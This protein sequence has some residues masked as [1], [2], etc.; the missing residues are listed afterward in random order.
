MSTYQRSSTSRF[1]DKRRSG[2]LMPIFSLPSKYGI[3][4]MGKEAY[5]FID[6]LKRSGQSYWQVLPLGHT[7]YGNSP[8]QCFSSVAGNPYFIDLD[9]LVEM[10]LLTSNNLV[11]LEPAN[12]SKVDY[13]LLED[14]RMDILRVAFSNSFFLNDDIKAFYYQNLDWIFDY[15]LFMALKN[16]FGQKPVWEWDDPSIIRREEDAIQH[17]KELLIGDIEF[18]IFIQY[19]FFKQWKELKAYANENGIRFIGDIPMYPSPDSCDVWCDPQYFKVDKNLKPTW[20][21][22]VPPDDFSEDGQVWGNPV[23]DWDALKEGNYSWWIWRIYHTL[24]TADIIRIDHFRAFQD[25]FQIPAGEDTAKNG[26]WM[27]GPGMDFFDAMK[28][29]FGELPFILEDLGIIT[30]SV[31]NLRAQ[32]GLPGMRVMVF[33]FR[34]NEDNEHMPHNWEAD[35]IAYTSTHDSE[36]VAQ[37]INELSDED[38]AFALNYINYW[39]IPD[40]DNQGNNTISFSAIRSA[41]ASHANIVIVAM[42]DLLSLG[43]EGRINTPSTIG[44][45]NWTWRIAPDSLEGKLASDFRQLTETFKRAPL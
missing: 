27:P 28:D 38:Y 24:D 34:A 8:Y 35:S 31:R 20:I 36:T 41:M 15:A 22:G 2:V 18:Y 10:G 25:Y 3:G 9:K 43:E 23:Y 13:A 30:D 32:T 39:P 33:G 6:F 45:H 19:L 14:T 26:I 1:F 42:P 11:G 17:Y 44:D 4:T 12:P 40:L 29:K 5:K 21:A 16:H 7:G 37:A